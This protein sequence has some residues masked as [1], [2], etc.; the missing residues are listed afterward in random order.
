MATRL[1]ITG[2]V[3]HRQTN[4]SARHHR[5]YR[6]FVNHL[7]DRVLKQNNELIEGLYLALQFNAVNEKNR[8]RN[9]LFTE[10]IKVRVL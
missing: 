10:Q 6:V 2:R 7:T 9:A 4:I 1:I 3:L 5:R 8:Y